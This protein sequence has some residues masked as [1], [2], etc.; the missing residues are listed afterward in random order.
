MCVCV[1]GSHSKRILEAAPMPISGFLNSEFQDLQRSLPGVQHHKS[2]CLSPTDRL[3]VL[4][5]PCT[6]CVTLSEAFD[7]SGSVSLSVKWG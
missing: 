1:R 4:P 2:L 5:L 7:L 3:I 6:C